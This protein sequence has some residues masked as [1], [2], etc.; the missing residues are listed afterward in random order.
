MKIKINA[1]KAKI[2][3]TGILNKKIEF[4]RNCLE[5]KKKDFIFCV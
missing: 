2:L 3:A 1:I 4:K 5:M